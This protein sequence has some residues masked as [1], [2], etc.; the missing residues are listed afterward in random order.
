MSF[1]QS[2]LKVTKL[3]F[4]TILF[5]QIILS[6]NAQTLCGTQFTDHQALSLQ[7]LSGDSSSRI[8]TDSTTYLALKIHMVQDDSNFSTLSIENVIEEIEETNSF[9]KQANLQF[10][11]HDSIN[12]ISDSELYTYEI[13][14]DEFRLRALAEPNVINVYFVETINA[15][16]TPFAAYTYLPPGPDVIFLSHLSTLFNKATLAHEL[17]HYLGLYHTHGL[18]NTILTNELV[19][20]SNCSFAGDRIC[21]T[22]A[23][24]NLFGKV[25]AN[26]TYAGNLTDE[27]GATFTPDTKNIMSYALD[28]CMEYFTKGQ[29]NRMLEGLEVYRS[30]LIGYKEAIEVNDVSIKFEAEDHFQIIEE[31]GKKSSISVFGSAITDNNEGKAVTLFDE[32]DKVNINFP[33]SRA[34]DYKIEARVRSGFNNN[35]TR[36]WPDGYA[37]SLNDASIELIGN[38]NSVSPLYTSFGGAHWGTMEIEQISLAE[39]NYNFTITSNLAWGA[40]D[41]IL[42]EAVGNKPPTDIVISNQEIEENNQANSFIGVLSSIDENVED[43][44]EF[45]LVSGEGD[46]NNIN[47]FISNDSL[48]TNSVFDFEKDTLQSIRIQVNDG[49]GGIYEKVVQ[50]NILNVYD[51]FVNFSL[52]DLLQIYNGSTKEVLITSIPANVAYSVTYNGT[53]TLPVDAGSYLVE[54]MSTD[55]EYTGE[56]I[57]TLLIEKAVATID[58]S[59]LE[60][61]YDGEPKLVSISTDPDSLRYNITYMNMYTPLPIAVGK[62]E[63]QVVVNDLNF[64]GLAN[65]QL[66]ISEPSQ[67][68]STNTEQANFRF[69]EDS[70]KISDKD[71]RDQIIIYPNPTDGILTIE[72]FNDKQG[73][74]KV[75]NAQGKLI[76]SLVKPE[77]T[78]EL[79]IDLTGQPSGLYNIHVK[80]EGKTAVLRISKL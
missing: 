3:V 77:S 45:Q 50:I 64:K 72:D 55:P 33:I 53:D 47:F 56:I 23:D 67:L 16:S 43:V 22:P 25:D 37:F 12:F 39:G 36:Y 9:F 63:L 62:Y 14:N 15:S 41:Y 49:R 78:K 31:K 21:D 79:M 6:S 7:L 48:Y 52:S 24:P 58:I 44:H 80:K 59:D 35:A 29:V 76:K 2:N 74:I 28:R 69:I 75:F 65:A 13:T 68:D 73:S 20:G 71:F 10:Y 11:I 70:I 32:G 4:F 19:D 60:Q 5:Q 1:L 18:S 38:E 27:N 57:D 51:S 46:F 54:V 40:L 26:C 8:A 30:Y 17:G 34:G 61:E 42:V 66:I